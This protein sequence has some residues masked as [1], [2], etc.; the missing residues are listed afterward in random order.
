MDD[1]IVRRFDTAEE[2]AFG[3]ADQLAH[4]IVGALA[5]RGVAHVVLTGGRIGT[6][7]LGAL[8]EHP[9]TADIPWDGVEFWWSDERFLAAGDPDRNDTGAFDVLLR[10]LP[11]PLENIHSMPSPQIGGELE[12]AAASYL[13]DVMMA[14][15]DE[16][17]FDVC[18]LG[19]GEDAHVASLFPHLSAVQIQTVDVIAVRDSPKPPPLRLSFSRP[20]IQRARQVWLLASG[21]EKAE[22][23]HAIMTTSNEDLA[24]ASNVRGQL[25]TVLFADQDACTS[26]VDARDAQASMFHERPDDH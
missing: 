12:D 22:A 19:V 8:R 15:D 4:T 2:L 18:L 3:I 5:A 13:A 17:A 25:R 9:L 21:S 26:I 11:V 24:P 7:C 16:V 23:V 20:L 14:F 1:V 10:H 6:A